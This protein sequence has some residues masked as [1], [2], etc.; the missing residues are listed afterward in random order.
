MA[1]DTR[2]LLSSTAPSARIFDVTFFRGPFATIPST[3]EAGLTA[4]QIIDRTAPE[5]GP[6]LAEDKARVPYFVPC[7]LKVAPFVGKTAERYPG[8]SGKQR[9]ASHATAGAIFPKDF[10]G[11]TTED[12]A[13][14][15]GRLEAS[16]VLFCAYST[17]SHGK[18]PDEVRMRVLV[19]MDR[20]LEPLQW[21][22]VWHVLNRAYF[23][24]LADVATAKLSQQAGVWATHP[25]REGVAWRVM[26]RGALLSADALL[27]LVPPKAERPQRVRPKVSGAALTGRYADALAM[28]G[29]DK[30]APWMIGL[31]ALKAG[32]VLGELP[33]DDAAGLWF[34]FSDSGS[35][36]AKT[37]NN[38]KRYDPANLWETW[39]PTAAP[40]EGLAGKLFASAR[41]AALSACRGDVARVGHLTAEGLRAARYLAKYHPRAFDELTTEVQA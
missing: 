26:N 13:R 41:D 29:A 27:A 6:L 23:D 30:F 20:A 14:L 15:L 21:T 12:K 16:G 2:T 38:D 40:A 18:N 8:Q 1:L 35:D 36:A 25:E 28:I 31:S 37:R 11:I 9:S 19:F 34:A 33:E 32:V 39:E 24:G 4:S 3:E 7:V 17:Y 22:D 10:D 5:D